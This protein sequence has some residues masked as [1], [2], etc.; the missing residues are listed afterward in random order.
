LTFQKKNAQSLEANAGDASSPTSDISI[1]KIP[2]TKSLKVDVNEIDISSLERN[3]RLCPQIWDYDV[4]KRDE[5]QRLYIKAGPHQPNPS[6]YLRFGP[7]NHLHSFQ[8]SWFKLFPSWLD[9][10]PDK[11]ANY[12][13][14]CLLCFLF[15]KPSTNPSPHAFTINGFKI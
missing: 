7:E 6:K 3:L 13:V 14:F 8:P 9:Y 5:I 12:A 15:S 10:L 4:N 1:S 11:D 2:P